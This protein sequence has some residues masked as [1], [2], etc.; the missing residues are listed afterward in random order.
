M[1]PDEPT[2]TRTELPIIQT[3]PVP[4]G[5]PEFEEK[6]NAVLLVLAA[7]VPDEYRIPRR[8]VTDPPKDVTQIPRECGILSDAELEITERF[9]ATALAQAIATGRFSAVSVA[10]AFIK[11]SIIC[12]QISCCLTQWMP[13]LAL[14]RAQELDDYFARTGKTIGPLH[15]VPVSIKQHIPLAD[16]DSD[17][18]FL[19][20]KVHNE[21]DS[22]LASNLRN[23]GAVFYCKT[24]RESLDF[25]FV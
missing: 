22:L 5:S 3:L 18:G 13:E 21:S 14:K 4:K 24:A 11:R 8:Y 16:T 1:A 12:H 6:R 20:T 23:L 15:G 9:D 17:M 7:K 10:E 25:F 19:A 2:S